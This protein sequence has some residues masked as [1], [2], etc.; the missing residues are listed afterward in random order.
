MLLAGRDCVPRRVSCARPAGIPACANAF[1]LTELARGEWA[2]NGTV[3]SDCDAVLNILDPHRYVDNATDMAR[4]AL[5]AGTDTDCGGAL[6]A[7]LPSALAT[8]AVALADLQR[9][10]THLFT[11][12]FR[13]G[14]FDPSAGQPYRDINASAVCTNA[15]KALAL[16]AAQQGLVLLKNG[17]AS[18]GAALPLS[19]AAVATLAVIGPNA[20]RTDVM[21]VCDALCDGRVRPPR[22]VAVCVHERSA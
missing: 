6:V 21:Q 11:T 19:R 7:A 8:G 1:L 10:A 9:A 16:S 3:V 12:R 14:E 18:G 20:D 22:H 5:A 2:F 17:G 13:L 4:V 15:S